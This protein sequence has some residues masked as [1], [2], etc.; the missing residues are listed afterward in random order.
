MPVSLW[1][2][3]YRLA[4]MLQEGP[5]EQRKKGIKRKREGG[6]EK[7]RRY[8]TKVYTDRAQSPLVFDPGGAA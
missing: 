8:K 6:K 7:G 4:Q 2:L 3:W 1:V 5:D